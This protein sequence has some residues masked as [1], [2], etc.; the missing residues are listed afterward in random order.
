MMM[1]IDDD[2]DDDDDDD[3]DDDDDDEDDDDDDDDDDE[4]IKDDAQKLL[5]NDLVPNCPLKNEINSIS[6]T[7]SIDGTERDSHVNNR[8][9]SLIKHI[10]KQKQV[11]EM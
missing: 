9:S 4:K 3:E 10:K 7:V 8:L 6:L 2:D 1:R 11:K 5:V